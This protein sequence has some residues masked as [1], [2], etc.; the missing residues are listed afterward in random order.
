MSDRPMTEIT[1]DK[2]SFMRASLPTLVIAA[3]CLTAAVCVQG[4]VPVV[5]LEKSNGVGE[6]WQDV[7]AGNLATTPEGGLMDAADTGTAFYRLRIQRTDPSGI[8]AGFALAEV[9]QEAVAIAQDQLSNCGEDDWQNA[10]L[11]PVVYPVYNPAVNG[12]NTPAYLEFKVIRRAPQAGAAGPFNSPPLDQKTDLGFILVS[13]TRQDMPIPEFSTEGLTRVEKL[14]SLAKTSQVKAVRYSQ[15]VLVAENAKGEAVANLGV[16]PVQFPDAIL[17]FATNRTESVVQDGIPVAGPDIPNFSGVPFNSFAQ[18]KEAYLNAPLYQKLRGFQ[19]IAAKAAWQLRDGTPP[20]LIEVS[21]QVD[22][23]ILNAKPIV[24]FD[25]EDPGIVSLQIVPGQ[26][27][28]KATG[29]KIGGTLLRVFY[30]GG[31]GDSFVIQVGSAPKQAKGWGS[32]ATYYAGSWDDQKRYSQ[33]WALSGCCSA[34]WSGCG[35]TAW[36]MLYGYWD[37]H[38]VTSLIG[39]SGSTPMYDNSYVDSCIQYVFGWVGTYCVGNQAATNPWQM[40]Q[41]YRWAGHQGAHISISTTWNVPYLSSGPRNKAIQSIR[42][43]ARPA[44]VGT[45]YYEHYP[46]AYGYKY[47]TYT[48]WGITWDTQRYWKVNNGQGDSSPIWVDAGSCWFGSNGY[49]Y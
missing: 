38:G 14:R 13:L 21:L 43:Y 39:G 15:A 11:G 30:A 24:R 45:G 8:P 2:P 25:V 32:W 19:A 4:A 3:S 29:L 23:N 46:L 48:S 31:D 12:G 28:L 40:D 47:R 44:L 7:P 35:P 6:A 16:M 5:H 37:G 33:E 10:M 26:P 22:T 17:D 20:A 9:S 49:C 36:A 27:G 34:G 42:D 41:G 1:K 18:F